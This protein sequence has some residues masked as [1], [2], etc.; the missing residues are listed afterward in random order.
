LIECNTVIPKIITT[1]ETES[2]EEIIS[3]FAESLHIPVAQRIGVY[4]EKDELTVEQIHLMQKDIQVAFSE[5]VLVVLVGVDAS[6]SEVQNSMLKSLEEDSERIQFLFIVKNA[7]LLLPTILS[8]CSLDESRKIISNEEITEINDDYFSFQ[9]N[10]ETK[11]ED[12]LIKID[13][14]LT[15]S[16]LKNQNT[17]NY[18]LQIR[19]LIVN[20]NM[21]PV[22]ALDAILIFLSKTSSM[23]KVH[24]K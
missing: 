24:E 8:R 3:P 5:K 11:K 15:S 9:N 16:P 14:L 20:N 7:S 19:S 10:S 6:S 12:A 4:P 1:T 17:L 2:I 21:N 18:V 23:N 22:S 13:K